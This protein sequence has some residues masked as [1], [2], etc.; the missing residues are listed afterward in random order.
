MFERLLR[1]FIDNY[2]TNYALFFLLMGMGIYAYTLIPKEVSP[3]IE[4]DTINVGG[5]YTGASPDLLNRIA[6]QELEDLCRNIDGIDA[7]NSTISPGRFRIELEIDRRADK[8]RISDD[9]KDAI[10]LSA[11]N[12]PEDMDEPTIRGAGHSRGILQLSIRSSQMP[13]GELVELA[14]TLKNRLLRIKDISDVTVFGDS[15]LFYEVLIDEERVHSYGFQMSDVV[16]SVSELSNIFPLGEIDN[17]KERYYLST[18]NGKKD[19][20]DLADTILDIDGRKILLKEL[21]TVAKHYEDSKTLASMNGNN[22]ITLSISQNPKGD[23]IEISEA[24]HHLIKTLSGSSITYDMRMDQSIIVKESLNIIIA[25]IILGIILIALLSVV[26]INARVAFIIALGIP[27]S[28][29]M[30]AIYFYFTGNSINVNSLIGVLIA[31]GIIVDDAIVVSENIQQYIEKGFSPKEAAFYGTKEMAKPVTV[32]SVTTLF[33][34]IPLLML[35]GTLGE[36]IRLI[37]IAFSALIVASLIESFIFLPIHAAHT[38]SPA[39]RTLSWQRI[40]SVYARSLAWL[41]RHQKLFLLLFF[42]ITPALIY[43]EVKSSKFHMF[44]KFDTTSISI[45]FKGAPDASLEESLHV[46]Q[47]IER[48]LLKQQER[49]FATFISSTAGYRRSATGIA[50]LY[51]NVGYISIEL[52]DKAPANIMDRYITPLLSPYESSKHRT[53]TK[54]SRKIAA[55]VR[56]WLK[57]QGYKKRLHL[58]EINV[59]EKGMKHNKA[60]IMI[61]VVSSDYQKAI[62]AVKRIELAFDTSEGIKYH[63]NN[64]RFGPKEIKLKINS[65]GEMLG[66]SEESIGRYISNLYLSRKI[67]TIFDARELVDVKVRSV[68]H[69]GDLQSFK[70]LEIPLKDGTF[71]P[72]SEVCEFE[73]IESLEKLSKDDGETTFF[74]YANIEPSKTTTSEVLERNAE[75]FERLRKEGIKLKFKGEREQ[76][77][78]LETE[79]L[80]AT[81]LALVLI[82]IAML[83]LFHSVRKTLIVMSVIPFSILGVYVGH[84]IMHLGISLPSLIGALGLAGV[85][86][87]DGI[88]MMATLGST[89]S[90]DKIIENA[91]KRLRPIVLTSVTTIIGLSSLIFFS[92]G[93]AVTFQPLA[94]ALGYGLFWGT[95]LNLFYVPVFYGVLKR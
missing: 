24:I 86:V 71:V 16:Q 26:L 21:A 43:M 2:K 30:G 42:I 46:A 19:A 79:M 4:P 17:P 92:S 70:N 68:N 50:E 13:H 25:N 61:G 95:L 35:S 52:E 40:N 37:P 32:A 3:E 55:D 72:L 29:V 45:T 80:L 88:I 20:H 18:Q 57:K 91:T 54:E 63:G 48:D 1:F 87:N 39:S 23:A 69:R 47:I 84:D 56:G 14:R 36:I 53:R 73:M 7:I 93:Q 94:V 8:S 15:D 75:L 59:V 12:L 66:L 90:V 64:I 33:S 11:A 9:I 85:I 22:A 76:K 6:V 81:A 10:A 38:L 58:E 62:E 78:T 77:N 41:M 5:S 89:K 82:F 60:D 49:F 65:Y 74:C 44:E 31:I 34:F 27:T 67:G 83:Y 28:F 51:P